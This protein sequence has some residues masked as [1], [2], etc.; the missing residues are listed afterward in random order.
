MAVAAVELHLCASALVG[1]EVKE[2]LEEDGVWD[3]IRSS[4]APTR[5]LH[6]LLPAHLQKRRRKPWKYLI[7][8]NHATL[9]FL[10]FRR[11]ASFAKHFNHEIKIIHFVEIIVLIVAKSALKGCHHD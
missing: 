11:L 4:L 3:S 8:Q 2:A 6:A 7:L 9:R 5:M 1:R 10:L